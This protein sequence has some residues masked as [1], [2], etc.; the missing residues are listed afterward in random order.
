[1]W[2]RLSLADLGAD[3]RAGVARLHA[4]VGERL[5]PGAALLDLDVDLGGGVAR[6]CPPV[7]TCRIVLR[8]ALWLR[9]LHVAPAD[10][11]APG[12]LIAELSDTSDEPPAP[13][14]RDARVTLVAVVHHPDWWSDAS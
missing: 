1:M 2:V 10:P 13:P 6:D 4:R 12:A 7:S 3:A 14:Q 11:V 5:A 8:E 9:A